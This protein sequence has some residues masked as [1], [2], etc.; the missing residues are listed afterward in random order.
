M[1]KTSTYLRGIIFSSL[2]I[3]LTSCEG[4]SSKSNGSTTSNNN[5]KS[6]DSTTNNNSS[7]TNI[8]AISTKAND[9]F[10][11]D[12][13][14]GLHFYYKHLPSSNYKLK[15]LNDD[16]FNTLTDSQKLLVAN[17]LL[18]TLFFGL[19]YKELQEKINSGNFISSIK[20][21]LN[22]DRTDKELIEEYILNK[23]IFKQSDYNE[24]VSIDILTRFYAMKELDS[25]FLKN[26]IAYILTQTIMFSPAYEL[27]SS[28]TPNIARVYNRIVTMLDVDSG[29]RYITYVHMMSEDNWRRF[30]S[31]EDN[32]REMMEIFTLDM[33]D[34][35]VPLAGQA[36]K[37]WKLDRE[38]DTL[39][40]SLNKNRKPI[41]L[42]GTTIY[43]GDDFYREMAKSS[44]FANGVVSRLVDFFFPNV[45]EDKKIQ[46]TSSILESKPETWQDILLQII[47]SEE[48]LLNSSR[49]KSAEELFFSL[50]KKI[51]F[52]HRTS[53][54]HELKNSL[55]DMHQ[56]SMKYKLGKL[57]RVPLDT[58]SFANYHKYI[59]KS[60]LT[61]K[62]KHKYK[63]DYEAWGR[64]GWSEKFIDD[65]HY[66]LNEDDGIA[67]L[68]SFIQYLFNAI[69]SRNANDEEMA[70]FK[71]HMLKD[72]SKTDKTKVLNYVFNLIETL[73]DTE[74]QKKRRE[75][76][77]RS[78]ATI[79]LDYI[80]RLAETY[81]H[82][83]VK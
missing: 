29:M 69:I 19:P 23:D 38:S 10:S 62:S 45:Q 53:T 58:L 5:S 43:T 35:H 68:E 17:K 63:A 47:F 1:F 7:I 11:K 51:D 82:A 30:R 8:N 16:S 32:G 26:W 40:V 65:S 61:R 49:A 76:R 12:Q 64:Q 42:F 81:T 2:I 41:K 33:D 48:Y 18:S 83:K 57:E 28:H 72:K 20:T 54:F 24:Q 70:L 27:E 31:P 80:S 77:K 79:V 73:E 46:L 39:L 34:S 60:I 15:Q 3:L 50:V 75:T 52:K 44:Q 71:S 4:G 66:V 78:I 36:L 21:G 14:A 74:E 13:Y 55:E 37:N 56:A 22:E 6:N 9:D 67:S 59:R 25:Y